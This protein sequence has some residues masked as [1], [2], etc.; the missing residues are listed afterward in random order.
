[1]RIKEK[2]FLVTLNHALKFDTKC[3]LEL[4]WEN[5]FKQILRANSMRIDS[6]RNC[7]NELS[8][9]ELCPDCTQPLHLKCEKCIKFVDDP[10]HSHQKLLVS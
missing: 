1:M 6:C 7:G 3:K 10:I 4:I 2:T 5:M 8:I 9:V